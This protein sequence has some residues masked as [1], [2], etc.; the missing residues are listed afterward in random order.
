MKKSL[1]LLLSLLFSA[2]AWAQGNSSIEGKLDA[3]LGQSF[4]TQQ[5]QLEPIIEQLK[6]NKEANAYW[7]AYGR[8]FTSV[9]YQQ[10]GQS[11]K[12]AKAAADA[13]ELLQNIEN[14][15]SEEHALLGYLLGYSISFDPAA[16][17]KLSAK[18][19]AQYRAAL[20]KDEN[21]LRA[22]VGLGV[23]DFYTPAN[24]GGGKKVEEYL[25]KALSLPEKTMEGGPSWG[26]N[27]A[28]H[29]LAFGCG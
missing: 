27:V 18:A 2:I 9:F 20:K 25:L 22:Y 19:S 16:A 15:N 13:I 4:A 24:V 6:E 29:M 12:A 10:T 8:F 28:Y 26:K 21:N 7:I 1:L 23:S 5:N 14:M 11:D 3:A 17:G